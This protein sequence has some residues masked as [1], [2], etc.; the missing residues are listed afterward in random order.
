MLATIVLSPHFG[1]QISIIHL[2]MIGDEIKPITTDG[3]IW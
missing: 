2:Q 1:K 3:I